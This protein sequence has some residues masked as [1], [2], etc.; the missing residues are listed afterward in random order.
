MDSVQRWLVGSVLALLWLVAINVG[1]AQAQSDPQVTPENGPASQAQTLGIDCRGGT[2]HV[3]V[4]LGE[5]TDHTLTLQVD[6]SDLARL[7]GG[8]LLFTDVA[9]LRAPWGEMEL[10]D[11]TLRMQVDAAQ[12]LQ[13]L[14]GA[15]TVQFP[16]LSV[17][18][19]G[20][21]TMFRSLMPLRAAIGYGVPADSG[22]GAMIG[23]GTGPEHSGRKLL[24]F[25]L[26]A[27][28]PHPLDSTAGQPQLTHGPSVEQSAE[29]AS[30]LALD[31]APGQ[32]AR[33]V[34]DPLTGSLLADGQLLLYSYGQGDLLA[35]LVSGDLANIEWSLDALP[36]RQVLLLYAGG[37]T[38]ELGSHFR[39][40]GEYA[41]DAGTVGEWLRLDGSRL[42]VGGGLEA[43]EMGTNLHA[44]G[45]VALWPETVLDA[46]AQLALRV[47]AGTQ[48]GPVT[49]A[50]VVDGALPWA[51]LDSQLAASVESQ[52]Y[53][54]HWQHVAWENVAWD[55]VPWQ[56]MTEPLVYRY[57]ALYDNVSGR[58]GVQWAH[59]E[60]G[61][62]QAWGTMLNAA[63]ATLSVLPVWAGGAE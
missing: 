63:P 38:G 39:A 54:P 27:G 58:A 62:N 28:Q 33:L 15:G 24:Y 26:T 11:L 35:Q 6:E 8:A 25:D 1:S 48:D 19:L 5:L 7:P 16:A 50:L 36:L 45:G 41:I 4:G 60:G 23:S 12:Q 22:L 17:P 40:G 61:W 59:V 21:M 51:G 52:W 30:V 37:A 9:R 18:T 10:A 53:E 44:Y 34:F 31:I 2:C 43:G 20:E 46:Q 42:A 56:N 32:K 57:N 3:Q 49:L 13:S 14:H 55:D 47:P 29:Q